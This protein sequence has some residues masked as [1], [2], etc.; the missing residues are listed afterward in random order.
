MKNRKLSIAA[1]LSVALVTVITL[2]L[3]IF[4]A[5]FHAS[6]REHRWAQLRDALSVNADQQAA[7]AALPMWKLDAPQVTAVMRSIRP[8]EVFSIS[9][10]TDNKSYVLR[11]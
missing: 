11:G 2:L 5:V 7:A 6:D 9:A 3:W 4:A 8:R 1:V 10:S